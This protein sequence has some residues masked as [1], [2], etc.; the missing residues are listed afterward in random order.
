MLRSILV[1]I[2]NTTSSQSAIELGIRW[3]KRHN[4]LLVGLG[5]VNEPAIRQPEAT[6]LGAG[7]FKQMADD[8]EMAAA[9]RRVA[10]LLEQFTLRCTEAGVSFK[11]LQDVGDPAE[12]INLEAQRYDLIMLG[13]EIEFSFGAFAAVEHSIQE[14]VRHAPRPVVC[15][16]EVVPSAESVLVA[17]DSSLQSARALQCLLATGL[18]DGREVHVTSVADDTLEAAKHCDRA[19][20]YLRLHEIK[21]TPHPVKSE[22][23][24]ARH[25]LDTARRVDAGLI[26]MGAY[27]KRTLRDFV[28]G[29]VTQRMLALSDLPLMLFH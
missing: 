12:E 5:V 20:E 14:V 29:S 21:A 18:L 11:L 3:A 17:Y 2:D 24:I 28:F 26:V 23:G 19:I 10:Q 7:Y 27:G 4:S 15:V 1:G 8:A 9:Q 13:R 25:L 16:P 6:P 22:S